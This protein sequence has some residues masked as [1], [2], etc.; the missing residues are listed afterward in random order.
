MDAMEYIRQ[1]FPQA[2]RYA[3]W[4]KAS[5]QGVEPEDGMLG[6]AVV[7]LALGGTLGGAMS[8]AG[9]YLA[10]LVGA[11]AGA[12][13]VLAVL[14]VFSHVVRSTTMLLI[15]GILVS[16][17]ASSVISLLNSVATE[18]GVHNYVTWGFGSFTGFGESHGKISRLIRTF[19]VP[20]V[21]RSAPGVDA[22]FRRLSVA[23]RKA[24]GRIAAKLRKHGKRFIRFPHKRAVIQ[25]IDQTDQK[26][27]YDQK[28]QHRRQ[29]KLSL[30]FADHSDTSR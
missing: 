15:V 28:R 22:P 19:A 9:S 29:N 7:M 30:Q 24:S 4:E 25:H 20:V 26:T 2:D 6:V 16:Y 21:P 23:E 1:E 12:A 18:E 5:D 13:L 8:G 10:T 17:M 14:M 27:E 11:L 3:I